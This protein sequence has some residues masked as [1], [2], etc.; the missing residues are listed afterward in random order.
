MKAN[1]R[2]KRGPAMFGTAARWAAARILSATTPTAPEVKST[3]P[4]QFLSYVDVDGDKINCVCVD[5]AGKGEKWDELPLG[6]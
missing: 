5:F 6:K 2:K 3:V 1:V 4:D